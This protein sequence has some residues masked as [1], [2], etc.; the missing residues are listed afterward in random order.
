MGSA[1]HGWGF[2]LFTFA[3][4]YASKFKVNTEKML[5]RLWGENYYNAKTGKYTT[6]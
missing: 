2:T 1:L 5:D 6:D 4:M 3:K